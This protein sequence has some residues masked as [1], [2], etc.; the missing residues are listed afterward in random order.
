[1][2]DAPEGRCLTTE[3]TVLERVNYGSRKTRGYV[4]SPRA[5]TISA[6]VAT[7]VPQGLAGNTAGAE[8]R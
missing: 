3:I 4:V 7:A 5:L 2:K 8:T 1:M 6:K